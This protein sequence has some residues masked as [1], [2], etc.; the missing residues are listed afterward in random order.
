MK[1]T[2]SDE[3][4]ALKRRTSHLKVASAREDHTALN[5]VIRN[6]GTKADVAVR[7][8]TSLPTSDRC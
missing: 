8:T 3:A 7:C 5:N 2:L 6:E 4:A 1:M